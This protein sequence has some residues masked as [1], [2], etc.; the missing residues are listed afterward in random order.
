M[1]KCLIADDSPV[2]RMLLVKIMSNMHFEMLEAEDGEE[3]VEIVELQ[4]PD[5]I[6]MNSQLPILDGMDVLYKIRSS[7]HLKQ[8]KI[9][10]CSSV[11]DV[12]SIRD[13]LRNGADDYLMKPFDEEI[14]ISK[15]GI[16]GM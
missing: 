2:I 11:K 6:I 16:L 5:L 13:A 15:L 1:P 10:F 8:P 14:I 4:E 3:T 9:I 7:K 12:D